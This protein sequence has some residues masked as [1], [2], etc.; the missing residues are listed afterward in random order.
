MFLLGLPGVLIARAYISIIPDG[1]E[2]LHRGSFF[3][4]YW[5]V[6]LVCSLPAIVLILVS[7]IW[8]YTFY[9]LFS[10]LY[11]SFTCNWKQASR[12][13]ARIAPFRKGPS[14]VLHSSDIFCCVMGQSMR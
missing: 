6:A 4:A 2:R 8:D 7:L 5:F 14:I 3:Y 10:L 9:Y 1:T 13:M 12:G 11:C